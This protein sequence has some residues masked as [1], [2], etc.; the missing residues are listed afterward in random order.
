MAIRDVYWRRCRF[1]RVVDGDTVDA[2]IDVG[3][4]LTTLQRL[5]LL[6]INT[7]ELHSNDPAQRALALAARAYT[8]QWFTTHVHEPAD[9][10]FNLRTEKDDVFGRYLAVVECGQGHVLNDALLAAGL[11]GVFRPS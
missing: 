1:K 5:R 11:A 7:P 9:W 2:E 3:F 8:E 10:P 4:L 6:G